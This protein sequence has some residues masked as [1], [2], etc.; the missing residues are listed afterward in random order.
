MSEFQDK[1]GVKMLLLLPGETPEV[2]VVEPNVRRLRE[3]IGGYLELMNLPGKNVMY[4]DENGLEKELPVNKTASE[5][6]GLE[7]PMLGNALI[8]AVD[9]S[10]NPD[11]TP[12]DVVLDGLGLD[13]E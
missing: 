1:H 4:V 7:V 13:E 8:T 5:I 2:V 10:K 11:G 12:I 9:F 6:A 3:I